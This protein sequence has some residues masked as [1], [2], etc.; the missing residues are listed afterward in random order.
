[1]GGRVRRVHVI[2]PPQSRERTVEAERIV[3]GRLVRSLRSKQDGLEQRALSRRVLSSDDGESA[4]RYLSVEDRLEI[5]EP[6][7]LEHDRVA[8]VA[9]AAST[10]P[11][12]SGMRRLRS[13]Q[14]VGAP[15]A[16]RHMD[17]IVITLT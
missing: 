17:R 10:Y 13:S 15:L 1:A 6:P 11:S 3:A 8:L 12:A 2:E 5:P 9:H 14:N 4:E 16:L 7:T